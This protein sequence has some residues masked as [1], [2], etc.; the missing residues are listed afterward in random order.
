MVNKLEREVLKKY[1]NT[2]FTKVFCIINTDTYKMKHS[3]AEEGE[4]HASD[5][6]YM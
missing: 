5:T 1:K 3:L 6:T 2:D 4:G